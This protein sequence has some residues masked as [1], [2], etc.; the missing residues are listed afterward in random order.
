MMLEKAIPGTNRC[1]RDKLQKQVADHI[2]VTEPM[3][4]MRKLEGVINNEE[5]VRRVARKLIR[6]FFPDNLKVDQ[7]WHFLPT[8]FVTIPL[9]ATI[10]LGSL[11]RKRN[12]QRIPSEELVLKFLEFCEKREGHMLNKATFNTVVNPADIPLFSKL[13]VEKAWLLIRKS[14]VALGPFISL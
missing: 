7:I 2:A 11:E 9:Q 3:K 6:E 8:Q 14:C 10:F 13:E 12:N 1:R 4:Y 5:E